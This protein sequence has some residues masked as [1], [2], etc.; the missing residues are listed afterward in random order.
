[1]TK[2]TTIEFATMATAHAR[3]NQLESLLGLPLSAAQP[4]QFFI[5]KAW[6]EIER[7]EGQLA[8]KPAQA[9]ATPTTG[10]PVAAPVAAAEKVDPATS[11]IELRG[12]ARAAAAQREGRTAKPTPSASAAPLIG[13]MRA[14]K[15]QEALNAS[16]K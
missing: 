13:V 11:A 16:R 7:L 2:P 15:A 6:D 9:A 14:A 5:D 3:I 10:K 12:V 1:M 4:D 8:A